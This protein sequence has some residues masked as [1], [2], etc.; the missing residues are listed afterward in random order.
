MGRNNRRKEYKAKLTQNVQAIFFFEEA[1]GGGFCCVHVAQIKQQVMHLARAHSRFFQAIDRCLR[2]DLATC[3]HVNPCTTLGK[4]LHSG[5][6]NSGAVSQSHELTVSAGGTVKTR[7][8]P[9]TMT[10]LPWRSG[11]SLAGLNL[12]RE[13]SMAQATGRR[14]RCTSGRDGDLFQHALS[15]TRYIY[16]DLLLIPAG[17]GDSS[18]CDRDSAMSV[19]SMERGRWRRSPLFSEEYRCH[20]RHAAQRVTHARDRD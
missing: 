15:H 19:V 12:L 9:V 6:A 18:V 3:A 2:F 11:R 13:K 5:E 4:M 14:E 8:P 1:F 17:N 20:T 7:L 10:T 16:S